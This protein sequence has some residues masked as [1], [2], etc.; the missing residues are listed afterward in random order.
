M[1]KAIYYLKIWLLSRIFMLSF[2]K[3]NMIERC[4]KFIGVIYARAWFKSP[5]SCSA[6]RNDLSFDLNMQ[7]NAVS[8]AKM[9]TSTLNQSGE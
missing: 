2:D 9:F 1:S 8:L 7:K 6:A 5:L 3:T 4:V